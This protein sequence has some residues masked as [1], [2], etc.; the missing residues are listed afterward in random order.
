MKTYYEVLEALNDYLTD[1]RRSEKRREEVAYWKTLFD[2]TAYTYS[3]E[4]VNLVLTNNP[5]LNEKLDFIENQDLRNA[6]YFVM[7]CFLV[8]NIDDC[9]KLRI[10]YTKWNIN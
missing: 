7:G 4:I 10:V 6:C 2:T 1:T 5:E 3:C 8:D 9:R